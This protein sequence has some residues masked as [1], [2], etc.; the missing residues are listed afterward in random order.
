[1]NL[2][3]E[4]VKTVIRLII[5]GTLMYYAYPETGIFT[6]IILGLLWLRSELD[7]WTMSMVFNNNK[8]PAEKQTFLS[9]GDT[10]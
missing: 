3:T 5:G 10:Q 8:L 9:D 4:I 7:I 2:K 6:T 1:M